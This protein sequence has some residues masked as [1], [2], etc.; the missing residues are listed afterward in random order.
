MVSILVVL[1]FRLNHST[2]R[3]VDPGAVSAAMKLSAGDS[4][5]YDVLCSMKLPS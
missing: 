3:H 5:A 2:A 1:N 4:M